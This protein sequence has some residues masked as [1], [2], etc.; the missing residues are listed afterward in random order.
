MTLPS[1]E[2]TKAETGIPRRHDLKCW[3]E[4]FH[5]MMDGLK[6]F[7]I[8]KND[9]DYRVG[10]ILHLREWCPRSE[11]YSGAWLDRRVVYILQG[12]Q[13]GLDVDH[14]CMA[15]EPPWS[16]RILSDLTANPP[17]PEVK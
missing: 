11:E 3:P 14:V 10:D 8:R 5:A 16:A 6:P 9:R 2:R 13:F 1:I 12:G 17:A 4:P 15:V 7:E